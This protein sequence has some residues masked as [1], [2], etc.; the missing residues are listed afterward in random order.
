MP[1]PQRD[2]RPI[3]VTCQCG[4][5]FSVAAEHAGRTFT[6]KTCKATGIVGVSYTNQATHDDQT[7]APAGFTTLPEAADA[8][9]VVQASEETKLCPACAEKIRLAAKKCRF[10]GEVLDTASSIATKDTEL[11]ASPR[12][13]QDRARHNQPPVERHGQR[14]TFHTSYEDAYRLVLKHLQT[15]GRTTSQCPE[16]AHNSPKEGLIISIA[17]AKERGFSLTK[18]TYAVFYYDK[19]AT[20]CFIAGHGVTGRELDI[21]GRIESEAHELPLASEAN[22]RLPPRL[23]DHP[24]IDISPSLQHTLKTVIG[25]SLVSLIDWPL[26]FGFLLFNIAIMTSAWLLLR[27]FGGAPFPV[28]G[29]YKLHIIAWAFPFFFVSLQA[30]VFFFRASGMM[31]N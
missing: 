25:I 19:S 9:P 6:C 11:K 24:G 12:A 16:I 17:P 29:M 4:K 14:L 3:V 5:R 27:Q 20:H 8:A 2:Q 31:S 1:N 21:I 15:P 26:L 30:V 18:H 10:C 22:D 28:R 13:K 23:L 7:S